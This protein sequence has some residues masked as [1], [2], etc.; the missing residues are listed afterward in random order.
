MMVAP[1]TGP[2][3]QTVIIPGPLQA[4]GTPSQQGRKTKVWYR[5][6]KPYNLPLYF[7]TDYRYNTSHT[8]LRYVPTYPW[9]GYCPATFSNPGYNEAYNKAY[10]KLVSRLSDAK[11]LWAVNLLEGKRSLEMIVDRAKQLRRFARALNRWEFPA[12]AA[13]LK[14]SAVP[15]KASRKKSFANNWLEFHFGWEP[16][17]KDIGAALQTFVDPFRSSGE[18]ILLR[19][20][21]RSKSDTTTRSTGLYERLRIVTKARAQVQ[22]SVS[23]PNLFLLEQLGFVNPATVLWE[24]VPFSFVVDWFVNVGQVLGSVSEW[25][26]LSL[27]N[28]FYSGLQVQEKDYVWY[29]T[30]LGSSPTKIGEGYAWGSGTTVFALRR[31]GLPG[32]TLRVKPFRGLS[33]TRGATAIAL[34][35]Q[36]MKR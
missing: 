34:L 15:P 23:N 19:G 7:D 3:S 13:I 4:N 1:V 9:W 6:K 12:A 25:I 20:S 36:V 17:V 10:E 16:L 21:G 2:F 22:V 14:M 26:G 27:T 31:T 5:Q 33:P 28:P 18:S 32:P 30:Q 8:D 29:T 11:S 24:T 35:L